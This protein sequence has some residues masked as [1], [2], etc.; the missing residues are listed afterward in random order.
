M[1][2]ILAAVGFKR[3][4]IDRRRF[5]H[6]L[7]AIAHR[8]PDGTGTHYTLIEG[9]TE[10]V[11][12]HRRL[13]VFDL[14]LAG[15]QPMEDGRGRTIVYNGEVFNW[16]EL[17][18]ELEACGYM[19]RTGTDTE[20]ILAAYDKWGPDCVNR[21][22]GF[23]AIILLD[24]SAGRPELF[25]SRDHFGIK[26]LYYRADH[27]FIFI[28]SE[29]SA[30]NA[31]LNVNPK[32]NIGE[33]A[34]HVVLHCAEDS[35]RT[36]YEGVFE[37]NP[38]SSALVNLETGEMRQWRYWL[39][40]RHSRFEGSHEAALEKFS[41]L[42][43]DAVHLRLRADR[44]VAL[45]LSGGIDSSAIA[46][47]ISRV[48]SMKVR[49]FTSHFPNQPKIDETKYAESVARKLGFEHVLVQPS[50]ENLSDEE[51]R[52]SKH[53]ELMYG[54]FSLLVNWMVMKQI[55]KFNI[56]LFLNGQGGDELFLGYERYYVPYLFDMIAKD[57]WSMPRA[58]A[59]ISRNSRLSLSEVLAYY[60]YFSSPFVRNWRY[61]REARTVFKE[62]LID[63]LEGYPAMLP[64]TQFDLQ[65]QEICGQQ[66][67]H[68]LR[69]DDRTAAAFGLES[70]PAF[71][72]RRLVEFAL[73]LDWRYKLHGGWTKYVVRRYLDRHGMPEIAWRREKLGYN[74]PTAAW[75]DILIRSNVS[76]LAYPGGLQYLKP[77][78][79]IEKMP[80]RMR[81]LVYNLLTTAREMRWAVI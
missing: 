51:G 13:A 73:S 17:R 67:R 30:I 53:Q 43:E 3:R 79:R 65:L 72:D 76:K 34:R 75:T 63:A 52:L 71:L 45:T 28:S 42:F 55:S 66:L 26:P 14:S 2:G 68:L 6:A 41:E 10:V 49:A 31:Y 19:F 4:W 69:Y 54:S 58:F 1:C 27:D 8:G 57:P 15:H 74:A 36:I 78:V 61:R 81:F 33:L 44:E 38:A 18:N 7:E 32:I 39:P 77:G 62:T 50:L 48:G 22:N 56:A 25:L 20:V 64:E 9:G 35:E 5:D 29:I 40:D 11:L 12:G 47:A 60:V 16:P 70:R 21:F 24:R 46:V 37:L 59:E 80:K 23:W